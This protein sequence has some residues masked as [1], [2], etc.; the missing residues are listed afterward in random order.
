M[1]L[2]ALTC[3][4]AGEGL[5][6]ADQSWRGLGLNARVE[7]WRPRTPEPP[8]RG[9]ILWASA[10]SLKQGG[11]LLDMAEVS[12]NKEVGVWIGHEQLRV[13]PTMA[14]SVQVSLNIS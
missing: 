7:S 5:T 13:R 11:Q 3:R 1:V 4:G 9:G 6:A 14:G 10:A 8:D 12:T 2:C